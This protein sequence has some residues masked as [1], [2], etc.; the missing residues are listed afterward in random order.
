[1]RLGWGQRSELQAEQSGRALQWLGVTQTQG[2]GVGATLSF[3]D[4]VR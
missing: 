1:M 4:W 2:D 3:D